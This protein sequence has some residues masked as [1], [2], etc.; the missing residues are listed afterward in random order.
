MDCLDLPANA[1]LVQALKSAKSWQRRPCEF[2]GVDYGRWTDR[3]MLLSLALDMWEATRV[4]AFGYPK[5]LTEGDFEG[6]FEVE[7]T[8]DNAQLAF[9]LWRKQHADSAPGVVPR[10][11][12]TGGEE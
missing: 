6:Y 8:Q 12:F 2:L 10:V 3:D 1:W 9:D 7:E 4:G 5:R 11:V